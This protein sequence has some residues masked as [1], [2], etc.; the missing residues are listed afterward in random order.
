MKTTVERQ[1]A[2]RQLI[3]ETGLMA[4][5]ANGAVT[6]R[7]GD[8]LVLAAAVMEMSEREG[9][10]FFPLT[11]DY[12]EKYY[13]SG[14][15]PGGFFKR[16][17]RPTE[18]ETLTMRLIDRPMRP[19]F[20]KGFA[21]ETQVMVSV[22]S[23]DEHNDPDIVGMIAAFAALS[24]SDIPFDANLGA[25][26]IGM[27][28][29]EYIVN[30]TYEELEESRLNL[31]LAGSKDAIMMVESGADRITE[32]EM[33]GALEVGHKALAEVADAVAELVAAAGKPKIEV[34]SPE[35]NGELKG[36]LASA[37]KGRLRDAILVK[38]KVERA[39]AIEFLFEEGSKDLLP[40]E[41]DPERD[42]VLK[43]LKEVCH[44]LEG[45]EMRR[46]VL[47]EGLRA[48]GRGTKDIRP[49]SIEIGLVP[50]AHGSALFT[51]GETQSLGTT[52]LG[53]SSDEQVIDNLLPE[54]KKRYYLHYNFPPFCT[55][56]VK[57]I[58]GTGRREIG[59]GMLA[60]RALLP[61]LPD[62]SHFPYTIRIVSDIL[63]SNGSS[64]MASV[65]SGCLSLMDAGVPISEPVA[66]I[67]MG[68]VLEGD[69]H[70]VLSD[71][72]G[73][74]DHLGDMDFKV[75]GTREGITA[76]QMDIKIGGISR[77]L[78]AE[79]LEQAR[80]GRLH[81]LDKMTEVMAVPRPDLKPHAPR[82]ETLEIDVDRIR[83]V[84]GPGGKTIRNIISETGVKIDVEDDGT[85][86]IA[87]PDGES[88]RRAREMV[89]TLTADVEIGKIY[90][91]RVVRLMTFGAF[92]EV[93]PGKEGLVHVSQLDAHRVDR[94]ED[95]VNIGDTINVKVV[96]IDDMGRINLSKKIADAEL[97][98]TDVSEME[99]DM[100]RGAGRGGGDRSS[101]GGDRGG[102]SGRGDRD[103]DGRGGPR[104][105][106]SRR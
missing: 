25:V 105:G 74:E 93:L 56:E 96:E 37:L 66:G 32:E 5:Q 91:G 49:I 16:E 67:A 57:F 75:T 9:I 8:T 95:V 12:R 38:G 42:E 98:G 31:T 92:V 6:A 99:E 34:V 7:Y 2:G 48:D 69:R 26:R 84:I 61:V 41:E 20:P 17:A 101:R 1:L 3:L 45:E 29:S 43:K 76:L 77:N 13:A 78:M 19:L 15:I 94:V 28:G 21:N 80:L 60:E 55:G 87:S 4:K 54:Y 68:L 11:V 22:L 81:I 36:R 23:A 73:M 86:I 64:S 47:E 14:K 82:I 30:P 102:R 58:R 27:I 100:K 85:V 51:R 89:E 46:M 24:I 106:R 103:R 50:K 10:D 33:I 40:S 104:G 65:C 18:K 79:A 52:T 62:K 70:A 39:K 53:T 97:A 90:T 44:D 63:E 35:E 71:I 83:D 72:L 88:L 59:H